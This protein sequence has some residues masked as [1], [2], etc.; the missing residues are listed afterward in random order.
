MSDGAKLQTD[1]DE[2]KKVHREPVRG[3]NVVAK[4]E[5]PDMGRSLMPL[6]DDT[7]NKSFGCGGKRQLKYCKSKALFNGYLDTFFP[8]GE[9]LPYWVCEPL[10]RPAPERL[11]SKVADLVARITFTFRLPVATTLP[12]ENLSTIGPQNRHFM[13][14]TEWII[15]ILLLSRSK[16]VGRPPLVPG[17]LIASSTPWFFY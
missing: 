13:S 2:E 9:I 14:D 7:P 17:H 16:S 5:H 11:N 15:N 3:I 6:A 1:Y 4:R 8:Y 12:S 10:E